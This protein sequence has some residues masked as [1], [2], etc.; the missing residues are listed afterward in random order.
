MRRYISRLGFLIGLLLSAGAVLANPDLLNAVKE[1]DPEAV[2]Q[3]LEADSHDPKTLSRPLFFAAQRG[4]ADVVEVLLEHGANPNTSF[5]YGSPLHAAA[6]ANDTS[7]L[8]L[9]LK[10]GADPDLAAGDFD[11]SP[12]HEAADRGAFEAATLLIEHGADVNFRNSKG[13]PP[14]HA[15]AASGHQDMVDFLRAH[16]AAANVPEPITQGE[17]DSANV[18]AGLRALHGCNTCHEIAEG[19]SATGPHVGPSLIGIYGSPRGAKEDYPYSGAMSELDGVWTAE[20][21]NAFLFDPTGVV[22]GTEMIRVPDMTREERIGL[23]AVLRD[24]IR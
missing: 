19:K 14:I 22:P 8:A 18:E 12:L 15:A 11:Q 16:G 3:V 4:Y 2:I 24:N 6:R 13:R 1:G 17:L 20:A 5:T 9:L 7:V 21:L 10:S 23:I